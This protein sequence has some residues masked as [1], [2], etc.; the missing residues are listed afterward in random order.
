MNL[1]KEAQKIQHDIEIKKNQI[2]QLNC[3][4]ESYLEG[5]RTIERFI[6]PHGTIELLENHP[7]E[8]DFRPPM[9]LAPGQNSS[10]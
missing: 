5:T 2:A 10:N 1:N 6:R 9:E 7:L 3:L 4:H 8:V